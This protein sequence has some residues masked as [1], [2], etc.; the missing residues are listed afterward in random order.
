MSTTPN[1]SL[2]LPEV[3]VTSGPTYATQVNTALDVV[4]DHDHSVGKGKKITPTGLNINS[5][6]TLNNN[7]LVDVKAVKLSQQASVATLGAIYVKGADLFY[8]DLNGLEVQLT[9][10]GAINTS[11]TGAITGLGGTTGVASYVS[12]S[13][14]FNYQSNPTTY[15]QQ[16]TGDISLFSR[17]GAIGV[18]QAIKLQ[19]PVAATAYTLT[20]PATAPAANQIMRMENTAGQPGKFVDVLGTANQ[21]TVTHNASD[22]TLSLPQSI[23]SSDA[24]TFDGITLTD[25]LTGVDAL[26]SS[27][28]EVQGDLNLTKASPAALNAGTY[29]ATFNKV[30][31]NRLE[32]QSGTDVVIDGV[33]KTDSILVDAASEIT[34]STIK[35]T[36]VITNTINES[37]AAN[38]VQVRG[39]SNGAA[40]P[41]GYIG[42]EVIYSMGSDLAMSIGPQYYNFT[43]FL[44]PAGEWEVSGTA[45]FQIDPSLVGSGNATVKLD[46]VR[47]GISNALGS[48]DAPQYTNSVTVPRLSVIGGT[49]SFVTFAVTSAKRRIR[50][51][52][53]TTYYFNGAVLHDA[54]SP[55]NGSKFLASTYVKLERV[56]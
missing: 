24:P 9:S 54:L 53:S 38:G 6:L 17:A 50:V 19:T 36:A 28:V 11:S 3:L 41:S 4:D 32:P 44:I 25:L 37:T 43:F 5:D 14:L 55:I 16:Y 18:V 56:G 45:L 39:K 35:P 34:M 21:V 27:D 49:T 2:T 20:L 8:R 23:D 30:L 1:M 46:H 15:A 10:S 48:F 29:D 13:G 7:Q 31:T 42:Q 51:S 12:A 26:F 40:I 47:V 52:S 22:I 33:V